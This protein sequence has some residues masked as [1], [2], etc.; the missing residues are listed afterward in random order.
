MKKTVSIIIFVM[1]ASLFTIQFTSCVKDDPDTPPVGT[2]P[3]GTVVNIADLRQMYADSGAYTFTEDYSVYATVVMGEAT[4]NIYK[5][6]YVQDTTGGINLY[7]AAS[8]DMQAGDN[9]RIY[10]KG[11]ELSEYGELMQIANVQYDSNVVTVGNGNFIEPRMV[12]IAELN[13]AM[14]NGTFDEY[15]SQLIAFDSVQFSLGDV[16]KTYADEGGYG[17]RF[18]EDCNFN[19]A[20]IRTSDYSSFAG[21]I[22]PDGRG[23]ITL[24][25]GRFNSTVQLLIRSTYEVQL[26]GPRCG[27]G[28]SGVTSID[29]DFGGQ[30]NYTDI[31]VDGWLNVALEGSRRWQGKE[32]ESET[33]AQATSFNSEEE[34]ECWLITVGIDLDAMTMP[35]AEFETAMAFWEHDGLEVLFSTDFNG[36]NIA[37]ATWEPLDC[38]IADQNDPDHDWIPSGQIDLSG[39]SGKGYIAFK[40]KGNDLN[41]STTS[42]RVDNVKVWDA[43]K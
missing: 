24:I 11:C 30:A 41:G 9:I 16:G 5:S 38:T 37:D 20:M 33:Y 28:G 42:Y 29:E 34:N 14:D 10:L 39:Y 21:E 19:A 23:S 6:A 13:A 27:A 25:A 32:F 22:I 3:V 8:S 26:N 43:G 17:E 7:M 40:Y 12:T 31:N 35:M 36:A 18:I 15:E 4:G 2:I 1:L